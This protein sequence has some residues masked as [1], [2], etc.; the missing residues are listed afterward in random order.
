MYVCACAAA[1]LP[2]AIVSSPPPPLVCAAQE[3]NT[4]K[5][6]T[7]TDVNAWTT[8]RVDP[9][10]AVLGSR[11]GKQFGAVRKALSAATP[12]DVATFQATGK[13]QVAG[14]E[15]SGDDLRVQATFK[16]DTS[17]YEGDSLFVQGDGI[18][19]VVLN[20]VIDD[21]LRAM[22]R[23]VERAC[24]CTTSCAALTHLHCW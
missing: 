10:Y 17:K 8:L 18:T 4:L 11:L 23:L 2:P 12:E 7:S 6:N 16:G 13:L 19:T 1:L 21:E 14:H 5:L 15:L 9:N 22:V 3:L 20:V 24:T